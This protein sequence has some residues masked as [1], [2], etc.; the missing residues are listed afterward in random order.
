MITVLLV[1]DHHLVRDALKLLLDA[2]ED[3]RVIATAA[4]G[5][6]A[7]EQVLQE[8]PQVAVLD[9]SMPVMDGIETARNLQVI[10]PNTRI[11]MLSMYNTLSHVVRA[12]NA[13]AHSYLLKDAAGNELI[14]AVRVLHAGENYLSPSIAR[15]IRNL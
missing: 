13:G 9:I 7:I 3:I 8:C 6:E 12:L 2:S 14:N 1:E 15:L 11:L 4:N 10:C 5:Q